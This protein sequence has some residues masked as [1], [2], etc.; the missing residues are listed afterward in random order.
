MSEDKKDEGPRMIKMVK[1][2]GTEVTM[3]DSDA[4]I[5]AAAKLG[6]MTP[7]DYKKRKKSDDL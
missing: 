5:Q 7:A 3:N 2:D 1:A 4:N 6:W